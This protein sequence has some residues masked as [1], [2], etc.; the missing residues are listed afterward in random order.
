MFG[1]SISIQF[2]FLV[3]LGIGLEVKVDETIAGSVRYFLVW[4]NCFYKGKN[5]SEISRLSQS[6]PF[7]QS[8]SYET[9]TVQN[10]YNVF[11]LSNVCVLCRTNSYTLVLETSH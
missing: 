8:S 2:S 1:T 5:N 3:K 11:D 6:V 9:V 7:T 4:W 10:E